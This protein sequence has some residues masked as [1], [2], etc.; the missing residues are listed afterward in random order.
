MSLMNKFIYLFFLSVAK[1][2]KLLFFYQ[3]DSISYKRILLFFIFVDI[4]LFEYII[5]TSYNCS[6][7][8]NHD[9]NWILFNVRRI[10]THLL[11]SFKISRTY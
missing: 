5:S 4:I 3:Q 8:L 11:Y 6:L 2:K 9:I 7:S 10:R 1:K